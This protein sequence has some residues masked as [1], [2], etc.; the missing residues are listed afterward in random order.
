MYAPTSLQPTKELNTWKNQI[1]RKLKII[2][3]PFANNLLWSQGYL[4]EKKLCRLHFCRFFW[5]INVVQFVL[6]EI[7]YVVPLPSSVDRFSENFD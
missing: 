4:N 7:S 1:W 3:L 2:T 5:K 6:V